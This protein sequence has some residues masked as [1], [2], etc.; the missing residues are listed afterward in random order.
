MVRSL[1][2]R[3]E[4]SER[5]RPRSRPCLDGGYKVYLA[6]AKLRTN[7]ENLVAWTALNRWSSSSKAPTSLSFAFKSAHFFRLFFACGRSSPKY[8]IE[9]SAIP[10]SKSGV[11]LQP[12]ATHPVGILAANSSRATQP[13]Q[14]NDWRRSTFRSWV[15]VTTALGPFSPE[16]GRATTWRRFRA[17]FEFSAGHKKIEDSTKCK[18]FFA[19][20]V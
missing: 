4:L 6:Q 18:F 5:Q 8:G 20:L 2:P 9:W 14:W 11:L 13:L 7:V 15:D 16:I 12:P 10:F 19:E 1:F 3:H 17:I